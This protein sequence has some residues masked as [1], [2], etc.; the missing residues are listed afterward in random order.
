MTYLQDGLDVFELLRAGPAPSRMYLMTNSGHSPFIEH[1][2]EF[3]AVVTDFV[4]RNG[5]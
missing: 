1:A 5:A 3:N 2:G 4:Q